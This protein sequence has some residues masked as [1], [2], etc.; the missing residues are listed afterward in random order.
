MGQHEMSDILIAGG[1]LTG[2]PLALALR[3]ASGDSGLS[4][5]V[6]GREGPDDRLAPEMDGRAFSLSA[7]SKNLLQLLGVWQHVEALAQPMT[8]IDITDSKLVDKERPALLQLDNQRENG[9][10]AAYVVE[11]HVLRAALSKTF[12]ARD[13]I[14]LI[15]P[16]DVTGFEV[17]AGSVCV[18][19]SAGE[20]HPGTSVGGLGWPGLSSS[21]FGRHQNRELAV[22]PMGH[23][24]PPLP[25]PS[26]ILG[27]PPSIF[28]LMDPLWCCLSPAIVCRLSGPRRASWRSGRPA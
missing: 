12:A 13:D 5:T 10:P 11:A 27:A 18:S 6:V 21:L 20:K 3:G 28:F 2:L 23:R 22:Q 9:E 16:A 4:V 26:L 7:A 14:N 19:S 25:I 24:R 8:R 15:S 17:S 1:G